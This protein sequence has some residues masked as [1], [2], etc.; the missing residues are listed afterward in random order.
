MGTFLVKY[1]ARADKAVEVIEYETFDEVCDYLVSKYKEGNPI[2]IGE[3]EKYMI[4]ICDPT[5]QLHI[6]SIAREGH[7]TC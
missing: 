2:V 1:E 7:N 4:W 3:T 5:L 6:S